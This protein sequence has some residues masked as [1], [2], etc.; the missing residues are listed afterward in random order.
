MRII[1]LTILWVTSIALGGRVGYLAG[2]MNLAAQI[3]D[4][5]CEVQNKKF[6]ADPSD[7]CAAKVAI[8]GGNNS[9]FTIRAGKKSI[10]RSLDFF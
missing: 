8:Y 4:M 9:R 10:E 2:D 1:I 7:Q 5:V 3:A 6:E